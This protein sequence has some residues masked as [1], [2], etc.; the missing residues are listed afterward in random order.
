MSDP[1][2]PVRVLYIAGNGR[3]GTSLMT[4]ILGQVDGFLGAGE[5]RYVWERGLAEN[6][7]C[8]CGL[9]FRDCPFWTRVLS[10]AGV[11]PEDTDFRRP[12]VERLNRLRVR[13]LPAMVMRHLILGNAVAPVA[14]DVWNER[15]Y[16]A[17]GRQ[18]GVRVVV[19]S[20]KLPPYG[21][22]VCGLRGL[23]VSVL[24]LMRDPRANAYSWQRRRSLDGSDDRLMDQQSTVLASLLW[25]I[26]NS[27][28]AWMW[29]RSPQYLR[30][31]YE[32]FLRDPERTLQ[33]ICGLVGEQP[34]SLPLVDHDH[35][36]L[37]PTH[38]V[39]G[40]PSRHR[41][42]LVQLRADDEWERCMAVR[43]RVLVDLLTAPGLLRWGYG[44]QTKKRA[45][46]ARRSSA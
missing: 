9:P 19:D 36:Q 1:Q 15:V 37:Q 13:R 24:H 39:A 29:G 32:D 12:V 8:G 27:M 38:S 26:W 25:L 23:D 41:T 16:A 46:I 40:N 30:V 18:P 34:Q 4:A 10:D 35:V 17:L 45:L 6:R 7:L 31:R 21:A 2:P 5:V 42:G 3:S 11:P 22:I 28:A 33:M 14:A 43:E 20:S 44:L